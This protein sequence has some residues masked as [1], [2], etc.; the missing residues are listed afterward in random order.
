MRDAEQFAVE[1]NFLTGR[2]VA[3]SH[4]D[5]RLGEWPPHPARL[6]SALVATW[7]D[8]DDPFERRALEWLERQAPP[9]IAASDAIPRRVSSHFVPVND[10]SV[11]SRALREKKPTELYQLRDQLH[12]E[13]VRTAGEV[14]RR[15]GQMQKKLAGKKDLG[16]MLARVGKTPV[17]S[18]VAM[19]PDGRGKQER[20]FP[21]VSPEVPRVT[22]V[23]N[24]YPSDGVEAG[25]DRLLARVT[26]LG[27]SSSLVSCRITKEPPNPTYLF[28]ADGAGTSMRAVRAG[29]L[30][31]LESLHLR[32]Q[33][34]RP[35]SLPYVAVRYRSAE[36]TEEEPISTPNTVGEWVVFE[37][38]PTSRA[39]PS[40]RTVELA[41]AMRRE[42]LSRVDRPP[43]EDVCGVRDDGTPTSM[44]H[45]A[46]IPIPYIA[47]EHA[48]GRLLGMAVSLP[49]AMAET[50]QDAIYRAI[51][52][53]ERAASRSAEISAPPL[54][55]T[56]GSEQRLG[57]R[58]V[59]GPA[60]LTSL[61]PNVWRK[62]SRRW[63]SATP[64]ALP[65]H[66]GSLSRGNAAVRRE[67][68]ARAEAAVRLACTHV[69]LPAPVVAKMSL[70]PFIRGARKVAHFP[71]FRQG[72]RDGK[73]V[74]RQ[75]VHAELL[76]ADPV[77]GPLTLGSGRFAGLG[78]M[79]PLS[80]PPTHRCEQDGTDA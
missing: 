21:S 10:A 51:G 66:P 71:A 58:R 57:L 26:R 67:A 30:T 11:F 13:L 46:I 36:V 38:H 56:L 5:R 39:Y 35:R 9:A 1:V 78:L 33:Q 47:F 43:P 22:Y 52:R 7:A 19:F 53:W 18:A 61:R 42:I 37:F 17:N 50:A 65:R 77:R 3:T 73:P 60:D 40:S 64:I 27:H 31:A 62:P 34:V 55:L 25:L 4:S 63:V 72:G 74:R 12:T 8:E 24:A 2:Y 54:S 69:G 16:D 14:T 59:A 41:A 20:A 6:F 80:E 28:T 70:S 32:H 49:D 45:M 79:R 68:W 76:F 15:V 44:P 23:W 75:L 29:Q 48:D